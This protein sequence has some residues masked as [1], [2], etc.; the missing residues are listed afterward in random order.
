MIFEPTINLGNLVMIAMIIV[1]VIG[2]W[3]KFGG[4]LDIIEFRVKAIE[5]TLKTLSEVLKSIANTD[6]EM[7]LLDQRQLAIEST[8]ATFGRE[9]ADLRRGDGYIQNNRRGNIDGEY[10]R[11]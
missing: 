2:G 5:D 6:K 9:L 10:K 4:R 7:A 8:V 11:D 1:T 3:Y